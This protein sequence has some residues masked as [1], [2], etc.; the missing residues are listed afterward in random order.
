MQTRWLHHQSIPFA[1]SVGAVAVQVL[2]FFVLAGLTTAFRNM[3]N[4]WSVGFVAV[5]LIPL[6]SVVGIVICVIRLKK[7]I[8]VGINSLGLLLN[9]L[10]FAAFVLVIIAGSQP[11]AW[12]F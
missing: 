12:N 6:V 3:G 7:K 4:I 8:G 11:N 10:Y 5:F 1:T 2:A 9:V